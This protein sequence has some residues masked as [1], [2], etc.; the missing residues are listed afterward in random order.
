MS[1][2]NIHIS[3]SLNNDPLGMFFPRFSD[4]EIWSREKLNRAVVQG[5]RANKHT[6]GI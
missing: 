2:R 4:K 6:G 1:V 3:L 5:P